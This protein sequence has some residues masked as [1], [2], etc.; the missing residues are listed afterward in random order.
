MVPGYGTVRQAQPTNIPS[1]M[2][3]GQSFSHARLIRI[4]SG[5]HFSL[6]SSQHSSYSHFRL[7]SHSS[8]SRSRILQLDPFQVPW[9][10]NV[11]EWGC[12]GLPARHSCETRSKDPGEEDPKNFHHLTLRTWTR[13]RT[14]PD[15]R[16]N[17]R[18]PCK[19]RA[20]R[21]LG[22][23]RNKHHVLYR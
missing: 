10:E 21:V 19:I 15:H 12:S 4:P 2:L 18:Q 11:R 3:T 20:C 17:S 8:M 16:I 1:P 13:R 5:T 7:L 14:H 6:P 23:N 9:C 22:E